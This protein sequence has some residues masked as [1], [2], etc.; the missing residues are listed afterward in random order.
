MSTDP[1]QDERNRVVKHLK[2]GG[3]IYIVEDKPYPYPHKT[4]LVL[5][6]ERQEISYNVFATLL[7]KGALKAKGS[8]FLDGRY[9]EVFI[10]NGAN[11]DH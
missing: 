6:N 4:I 7:A 5:D 9:V 8:S 1:T 2:S 10:G 3:E 11:D